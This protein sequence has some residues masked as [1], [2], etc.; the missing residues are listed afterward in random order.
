MPAPQHAVYIEALGRTVRVR[1]DLTDADIAT[2]LRGLSDEIAAAKGP[3]CSTMGA[4]LARMPVGTPEFA[5]AQRLL[6]AACEPVGRVHR[7]FAAGDALA[8]RDADGVPRQTILYLR[9]RSAEDEVGEPWTALV[10]A[11]GAPACRAGWSC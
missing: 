5:D 9:F 3:P 2:V 4:M 11:D 10:G 6:L 7:V 1:Q 8:E